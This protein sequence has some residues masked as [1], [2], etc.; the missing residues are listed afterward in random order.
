VASLLPNFRNNNPIALI[1]KQQVTSHPL[2]AN[3]I[4]RL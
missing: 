2:T 3:T 4:V 1:E